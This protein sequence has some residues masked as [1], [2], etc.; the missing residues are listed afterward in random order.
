MLGGLVVLTACGQAP[1]PPAA[2]LEDQSGHI[3]L[4]RC[5]FGPPER[6]H[7]S[8]Y[9]VEYGTVP[10]VKSAA[11]G[12]CDPTPETVYHRA[13]V[14]LEKKN[15]LGFFSD[16]VSGPEVTRNLFP[17]GSTWRRNDLLA[18]APCVPGTY[19]ARLDMNI[20][21]P[22]QIDWPFDRSKY[23]SE[24]EVTCKPKKVS[25][26]IDDTGS[27]SDV[28]GSVS[29]ALN[30]YI[31][32]QPEDEY[33][34][35]NLTTFKDSP[36]NFGTTTNRAQALG[37]VGGLYASGGG[38][39]PEDALGGIAAGLGT[40]RASGEGDKQ[41]IVATDASAQSGDISGIIASA[42]A[43]GVKVNVLLTGDCDFPSTSLAAL[44]VSSQSALRRIAAE[45]GGKYFF[46]P[47][48]TTADFSAALDQIFASIAGPP[49]GDTAPPTLSLSVTPT[50]LW[51]PDHKLVQIT[52]TVSATDT[53]DPAPVV[54]FVGVEVSEPADGQGDGHTPDDVQI[55][56]DGRI[57][58]RAERSG[59][60]NGRV[61]TITYKA[62]DASGN[63]AYASAT[64]TVPK[65]HSTN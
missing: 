52:P 45:T 63:V 55:T 35:W 58:V 31:S 46:I 18:T 56:P 12:T 27:M 26:V 39:C 49:P 2:T 14:T 40:L 61:Y 1:S 50:V 25:M 15:F 51:V 17:A 64:V 9:S 8:T 28:I 21:V 48:G 36:T 32:A 43:D 7:L 24:V 54:T 59:T 33:T 53:V 44:E 65:S 38:D 6:P 47:G 19:R 22:W 30:S 11:A 60:G 37:W 62:T 5:S 23:S 34:L 16:F 42:R 10:E 57:F 13:Q 41:M 3:Y 29:S 4:V 20:D